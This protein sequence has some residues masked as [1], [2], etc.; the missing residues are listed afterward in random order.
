MMTRATHRGLS[1]QSA[2]GWFGRAPEGAE[3]AVGSLPPRESTGCN[4]EP[5]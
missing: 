2:P 4:D 5:E 1:L 3:V